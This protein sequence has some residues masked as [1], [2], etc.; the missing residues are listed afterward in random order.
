MTA[1]AIPITHPLAQLS[2]LAGQHRIAFADIVFIEG[3]GN[4]T[5]FHTQHEKPILTSKSLSFYTEK[6]SSQFLRVHKS[7]FVNFLYIKAFDG[8]FVYLT[9]GQRIPVSRRRRRE[10]KTQILLQKSNHPQFPLAL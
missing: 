9:D 1:L 3:Q 6:L 8:E 4:Y 2:L 7:Y 10:V 5:L